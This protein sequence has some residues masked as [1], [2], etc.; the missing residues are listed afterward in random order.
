ME[1]DEGGEMEAQD[2]TSALIDLMCVQ[3][4]RKDGP[5]DA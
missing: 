4:R 5:A 1:A 3:G 2:L